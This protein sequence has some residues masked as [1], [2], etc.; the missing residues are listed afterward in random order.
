MCTFLHT[1]SKSD[2]YAQTDLQHDI[3]NHSQLPVIKYF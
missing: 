1:L 3:I 2:S